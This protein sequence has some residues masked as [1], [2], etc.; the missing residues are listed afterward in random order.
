MAGI[1]K[2]AS[3]RPASPKK[4]VARK[5]G[6]KG[7]RKVTKKKNTKRKLWKLYLQS[8]EGSPPRCCCFNQIHE[9]HELLCQ[10]CV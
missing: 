5:G 8:F 1:P 9:D 2:K 4:T 7:M 3:S 10:R 6:K